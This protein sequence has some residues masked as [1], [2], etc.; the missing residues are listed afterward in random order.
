MIKVLDNALIDKIAAGEVVE[1]PASVVKELVENSIDAEAKSITVEIRNGGIDYIRVAD[2]GKGI[3]PSQLRTAFMRHAT[4]KIAD[5][6]DLTNVLTLGFRGEALSSIAGV[7]E[8]E[9]YSKTADAEAGRKIEISG[10]AVQRESDEGGADGTDFTVRN[11]FYNVPARR[12]FLK[13]PSSESGY[14]TD[15]ITKNALGNP[16]IA[17]KFINNGAAMFQTNGS[18]NPSDA[19]FAVY[20]AEV[21]KNMV[22]AEY[23][24]DGYAVRGLVGKNELARANRGYENFYVNGRYVKN[25]TVRAAV[26]DAYSTR[27]PIGKFPVYVI[28][29]DIAPEQCDVNVHPTKLEVRF[30]D[31]NAVYN[32]MYEAVRGALDVKNMIPNVRMKEEKGKQKKETGMLT[33]SDPLAEAVIVPRSYDEKVYAETAVPVVEQIRI[34][35]KPQ[36]QEKSDI[37]TDYR[38]VGQVF[39]TY[40]IIEQNGSLFYMDQ[41]AAH[42]RVLYEALCGQVTQTVQTQVLLMPVAINVLPHEREAVLDNMGLLERLGYGIEEL[43]ESAV[44]V[45]SVPYIFGASAGLGFFTDIMDI[46][47]EDVVGKKIEDMTAV[48]MKINYIACRAAVK[49]NDRLSYI[50]AKALVERA[51]RLDNPF[52]CPHGRPTVVKVERREIERLFKRI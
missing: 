34:E 50:E 44:A 10:G 8:I 11:L 18:G 45:R 4:S 36:K 51:L 24:K 38:I 35:E 43:G 52:T 25:E 9:V 16:H 17:F 37:F 14:I 29:L 27:L 1:R 48:A 12:K 15:V 49:A 42:E 31:D 2:N 3:E 46:L 33:F 22:A 28:Y 26:T 5:L 47:I 19:V 40:W 30:A 32:V 6:D 21:A 13:R 23:K 20:G 39:A 7:A 41:H